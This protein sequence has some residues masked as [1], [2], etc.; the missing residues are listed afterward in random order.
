[1]KISLQR[2]RSRFVSWLNFRNPAGNLVA[3]HLSAIALNTF[4]IRAVLEG[5]KNRFVPAF[6]GVFRGFP[7][8]TEQCMDNGVIP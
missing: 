4:R 6:R 7:I 2:L 8:M 3:F 5:R 1:M